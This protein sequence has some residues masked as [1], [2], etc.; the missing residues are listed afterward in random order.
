MSETEVSKLYALDYNTISDHLGL[1]YLV[2]SDTI[3]TLVIRA[4]NIDSAINLASDW[5]ITKDDIQL[6]GD[7]LSYGENYTKVGIDFLKKMIKDNLKEMDLVGE[8]K[9]IN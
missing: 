6:Y 9:I 8:D 7:T 2:P 3:C 1:A 5:V 4:R